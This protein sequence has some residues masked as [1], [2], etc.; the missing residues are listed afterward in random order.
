M[1]EIQL[2]EDWITL[3][4]P[5]SAPDGWEVSTPRGT[6]PENWYAEPFTKRTACKT[7]GQCGGD[8]DCG[9]PYNTMTE[10]ERLPR[11]ADLAK[12]F[13]NEWLAF[14]TVPDE[15]ADYEPVHGKLV[16]HSPNP[17]DLYDAVNSVLWN[18]HVYTFFNGDYEA[19]QASYGDTW[20]ES[21]PTPTKRV[22]SGPAQASVIAEVYKPSDTV[23]DD[24]LD[25]AY[26]AIEQLYGLP[27]LNEAIRR[28]RLTRVRATNQK[29][30]S[31]ITICDQA[32]DMLENSLPRVDEVIWLLEESLAELEE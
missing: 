14:I 21:T 30:Q 6:E 8:C 5:A 16:A 13:P 11:I 22:A 32:L 18:Q 25:L 12:L 4:E 19:L 24:L 27:K 15:D 2:L 9:C 7:P 20:T 10:T 1:S 29:H 23:S 26:S 3:T 17:D 31:L 28:L